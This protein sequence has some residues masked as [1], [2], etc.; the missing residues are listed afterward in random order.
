MQRG[1]FRQSINAYL[2][3]LFCP[4]LPVVEYPNID[5]KMND[6]KKFVVVCA[7]QAMISQRARANPAR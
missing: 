7:L 3:S 4:S 2:S 1:A 6:L 5:S